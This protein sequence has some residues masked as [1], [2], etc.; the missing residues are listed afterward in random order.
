M[1]T[2]VYKLTALIRPHGY[3]GKASASLSYSC[4]KKTLSAYNHQGNWQLFLSTRRWRPP[5]RCRIR[6][7]WRRVYTL[8]QL[9]RIYSV[10]EIATDD[11][12]DEDAEN[13]D[14]DDS[15]PPQQPSP[16][17]LTRCWSPFCSKKPQRT[18]AY[19]RSYIPTT[20][21]SFSCGP[22]ESSWG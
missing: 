12:I 3:L 1:Y 5:F 13:A 8:R 2:N 6:C 18:G 19:S 20:R 21:T 17:L 14:E 22:I 4:E 11:R 7:D 15:E 10:P 16:P 9:Q